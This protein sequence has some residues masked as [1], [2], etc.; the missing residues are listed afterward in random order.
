MSGQDYVD[1]AEY[2]DLDH[3]ITFDIN[4]YLDYAWQAGSPILELA[5]GTG[6]VLIPIARAGYEIQGLDISANMLDVCRRAVKEQGLGDRVLLTEADMASFYVPCKEFALAF[7]AL[8]SF[9]HLLTRERQ[10]ACLHNLHEH[11]QPG[12]TLL[13]DVIALDGERLAEAPR[14]TFAVAREFEL[15]DGGR[16]LRKQRLAAHDRGRQVRRFEFLFEEYDAGGLLV[17]S[18]LVPVQ[19]RYTFFDEMV[20]LLETAGFEV[21]EVFRDYNKNPYDG[22]GEM[23]IVARRPAN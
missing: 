9:M 20:D 12:G 22:T 17:N 7:L 14:E 21:R 16:V 23:I 15:P 11:L 5:C 3:A 10:N 1:F 2:Y 6:R 4:F 8:R 19:T 18:R 13:I